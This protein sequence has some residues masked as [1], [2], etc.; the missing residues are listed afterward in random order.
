MLSVTGLSA[1]DKTSGVPQY[2]GTLTL[3]EM[4]PG[5]SPLSWDVANWIWNHPSDT[6]LYMEHLLM[7]DLRKGPRG[8]K[9]FRL[10]GDPVGAPDKIDAGIIGFVT[11]LSWHIH[12]QTNH[13]VGG[14]SPSRRAKVCK[15]AH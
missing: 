11:F 2:G 6:G 7:G 10:S 4:Y 14:S 5:V 9:Q 1:A 15:K 3:L 12:L 13:L 8:S